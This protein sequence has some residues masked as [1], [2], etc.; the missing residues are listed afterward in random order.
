MLAFCVMD[1]S[2]AFDTVEHD[3]LLT[4][5][6]A[7]FGL[8]DSAIQ[9]VESYLRPCGIRIR[10]NDYISS[11]RETPFA[12]P[13]GSCLGPYLYL[14]YAST[15]DDV[16]TENMGTLVGFA[17]DHG[18]RKSF[19]ADNRVEESQPPLKTLSRSLKTGWSLIVSR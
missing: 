19:S 14:A 4:V 13:Q 17:D 2:A 5:L 15:L 3:L 16:V 10:V 12:V 8:P 9:W 7:R 11:V 6:R 1:L 18:L